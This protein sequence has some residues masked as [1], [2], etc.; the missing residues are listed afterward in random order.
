MFIPF[1]NISDTNQLVLWASTLIGIE[2]GLLRLIEPGLND[3]I[4]RNGGRYLSPFNTP[5]LAV[6]GIERRKISSLL[7]KQVVGARKCWLN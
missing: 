6:R 2:P 7:E 1:I 5:M 4:G 3:L